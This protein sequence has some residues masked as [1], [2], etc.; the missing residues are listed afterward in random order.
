MSEMY[1]VKE[2]SIRVNLASLGEENIFPCAGFVRKSSHALAKQN[3]TKK[4][5]VNLKQASLTSLLS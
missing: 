5:K 3:K 1:L 4:K 2:E